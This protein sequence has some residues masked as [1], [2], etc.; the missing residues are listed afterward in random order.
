MI[1]LA[2]KKNVAVFSETD[3]LSDFFF[4]AASLQD[5]T[6]DALSM[7]GSDIYNAKKTA[8]FKIAASESMNGGTT[9][10]KEF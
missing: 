5:K 2:A 10:F 7:S 4:L 6:V 8:S 9:F 3:L 1:V